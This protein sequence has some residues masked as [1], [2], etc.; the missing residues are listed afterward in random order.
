MNE[1]SLNT[2]MRKF[3]KRVGVTSQHEIEKALRT[4]SEAGTLDGSTVAIH[5]TLTVDE[6]G[7]RHEVDG[8]LVLEES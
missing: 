8:E 7:L 6:V 4:A 2:S 3:L 5:V 1:E